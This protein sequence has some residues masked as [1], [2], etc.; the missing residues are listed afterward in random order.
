M[1][2]IERVA[3]SEFEQRFLRGQPQLNPALTILVELLMNM[4]N[5]YDPFFANYIIV[6]TLEFVTTSCIESTLK[7][8]PLLKR[9]QRLPLFIREKAGV[10]FGT[11][12]TAFPKSGNFTT[13]LD[14][15]QALPDMSFFI[16]FSNDI[17]SLV[18]PELL[19]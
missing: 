11:V 4:W 7:T 8:M 5:L 12:L 19:I 17:L 18:S 10:G 1:S 15:L 14:I 2:T 3:L 6:S 13:S 9:A 16:L